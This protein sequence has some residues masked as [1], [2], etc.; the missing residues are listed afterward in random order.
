MSRFRDVY[1]DRRI[2]SYPIMA[3]PRFS[4][5][6]VIVDSGAEAA[7]QKWSQALYKFTIPEA[8]RTMEVYDAVLSHW[9][10]MGG[11]AYIFPFR[12]PM[13]FASKVLTKP[14]FAPSIT[15][16]DQSI[17]VG[18][19][20]KLTFQIVKNYQRGSYVHARK[21]YLPVVSSVVVGVNGV[22]VMSGWSV[23]RTT[24]IITFT[25]PPT[26]G[27]AIT[28]GYLYD[29]VVR[30]ENDDS[31]DGISRSYGVAGYSDLTFVETVMC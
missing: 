10:I 4:T 29:I 18:D 8:V 31:F 1:L 3:S 5:D 16:F 7:N 26:A 28:C 19:G 14:A 22:Q 13:D 23:N 24:G 11:P 15:P 17:G 9:M 27:H 21:I 2:P 30:F 25:A 20:A 12:N 6:I